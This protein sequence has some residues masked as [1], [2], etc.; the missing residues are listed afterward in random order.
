MIKLKKNYKIFFLGGLIVLGGVFVYFEAKPVSYA[1]E[2][3]LVQVVDD[4]KAQIDAQCFG[5]IVSK[6]G[7]V[8]KKPLRAL[9]NIYDFIDPSIFITN[10]EF[11]FYLLETGLS[12]H[13]GEFEIKIVC[14]T[15]GFRGVSYSIINN[16]NQ[17]NCSLQGDGKVLI[18]RQ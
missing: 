5:D 17:K 6:Q 7:T 15:K 13:K 8:K 10:M 3:V 14:Y 11:G 16:K 1:P 18:C 12:K 4:G 2:V 9:A